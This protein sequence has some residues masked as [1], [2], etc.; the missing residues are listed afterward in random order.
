M[1][2]VLA[3]GQMLETVQQEGP[4]PEG[5]LLHSWAGS[6]EMTRSLCGQPG[7]FFSLSGHS[8]RLHPAK[9]Q[10]MLLEVPSLF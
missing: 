7:V 8:L 4:F 5:L 6:A 9:L 10:A 1:H 2:C 3:Y